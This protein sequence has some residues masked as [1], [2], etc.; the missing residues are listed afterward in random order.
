M[1]G[2]HDEV[3]LKFAAEGEANLHAWAHNNFARIH[4]GLKVVVIDAGGGT[5]DVSAYCA[6]H[7]EAQRL[8]FD[9]IA[10]AGCLRAGSTTID[11]QFWDLATKKLPSLR[12]VARAR[13]DKVVK[14]WSAFKRR[15]KGKKGCVVPLQECLHGEPAMYGA[16][17]FDTKNGTWMMTKEDVAHAFEHSVESTTATVINTLRAACSSGADS[18]DILFAGGLSENDYFRSEVQARLKARKP[19]N[20]K[21]LR[22]ER[23]E[24]PYHK[25]V[26]EGAVLCAV[27]NI[28]AR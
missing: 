20:V 7:D 16:E 12:G 11:E 4:Q 1:A 14:K 13:K 6:R 5:V 15:L 27:D 3:E 22:Y 8:V 25:S 23:V 2:F 19:C 9:E 10:P 21:E 18:F 26:A 17:G 24:A 28:I